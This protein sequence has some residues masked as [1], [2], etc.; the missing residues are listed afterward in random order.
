MTSV[1]IGRA[2][3]H[4]ETHT[5]TD[6]QGMPKVTSKPPEAETAA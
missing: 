4:T 1:L 5:H 2:I 3:L 6:G